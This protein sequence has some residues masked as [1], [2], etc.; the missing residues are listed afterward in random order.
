MKTITARKHNSILTGFVLSLTL[1][2]AAT[3]GVARMAPSLNSNRTACGV[4]TLPP[5]TTP[6]HY[7]QGAHSPLAAHVTVHIS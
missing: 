5:C 6:I 4:D 7:A 3:F 2:A 1:L